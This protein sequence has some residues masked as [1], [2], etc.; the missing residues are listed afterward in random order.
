MLHA[1]CPQ[2]LPKRYDR[3]P[4]ILDNH[5]AEVVDEALHTL[6]GAGFRLIEWRALLYRRM[7]V[8]ILVKDFSY[9]VPDGDVEAASDILTKLG[10]PLSPTSTFRTRCD[11]DFHAKGR[12][13][14]ITRSTLESSV[15][16][17]V[18][19]PLSFSSLDWS[20]VTQQPPYHIRPSAQCQNIFVPRPSAVYAS[21]IR[22]MLSYPRYCSTRANLE[23]DLSE[24]I[25][26]HLLG[27]ENGYVDPDDDETWEGLEICRRITDAVLSVRQW[28]WDW[29]WR[30]GEEWIGDALAGVV[31]ASG[32][33]DIEYLPYKS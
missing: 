22:I 6:Q 21:L 25:G 23:S 10:L 32:G 20:E 2:I 27:L 1:A 33:N 19:Y 9:I 18:L 7:K 29:E 17:F 26:Y 8:P 31:G 16:H 11:G 28:S 24:L 3:I 4:T 14:R 15:Q 30:E 12:F 5:P 13:H